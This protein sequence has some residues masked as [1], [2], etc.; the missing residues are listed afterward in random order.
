MH[1]NEFKSWLI[2]VMAVGINKYI[3]KCEVIIY[4]II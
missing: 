1:L 2:V 3:F 4:S